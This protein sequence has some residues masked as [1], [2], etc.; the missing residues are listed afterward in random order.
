[1]RRTERTNEDRPMRDRKRTHA[2]KSKTIDR[3]R[4][5]AAKRAI[6]EAK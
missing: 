6:R 1:M 3:K 5:R 2:A 4:Q